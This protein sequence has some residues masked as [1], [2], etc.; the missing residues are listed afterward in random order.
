MS[1]SS[2]GA[3][4]PHDRRLVEPELTADADREVGDPLRVV[5]GERRLRVDHPRERG[6]DVVQPLLVGGNLAPFRLG[7]RHGLVERRRSARLPQIAIVARRSETRR[8]GRDRTSCRG[9]AAP[10][11]PRS[12]GSS[13]SRRSRRPAPARRCAPAAGCCR[14]AGRRDSRRRPSARPCSGSPAPSAARSRASARS[15]RRDRSAPRTASGGS[16]VPSPR[17]PRGGGRARTA[18]LPARRSRG[19]RRSARAACASRA[20]TRRAWPSDR[21]RRTAGR[22]APSCSSSR[23]PSAAARR[24][25]PTARPSDSPRRPRDPHPDQAAARG[26]AARMPLGQVQRVGQ[27]GQDRGQLDR[28]CGVDTHPVV[29]HV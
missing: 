21:R 22:R 20:S 18:C 29:V 23:R 8:R 2:A 12:T 10:L 14:A 13:R 11:R 9:A 3:A 7:R 26:M 17:A 6:G 4:Q 27:A 19:R 15:R 28:S 24:T 1:C 16:P 25:D 5:I